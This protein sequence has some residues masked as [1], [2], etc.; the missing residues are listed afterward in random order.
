MKDLP[1]LI[2]G[3][4]RNVRQ[5]EVMEVRKTNGSYFQNHSRNVNSRVRFYTWNL[6]IVY[7]RIDQW[8]S[9]CKR[10]TFRAVRK[11]YRIPTKEFNLTS[12]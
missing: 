2:P 4:R 6:Q 3:K 1:S 12:V 5:S 7:K 11:R 9:V 10:E 8:R